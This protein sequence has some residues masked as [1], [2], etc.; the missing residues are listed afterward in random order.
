[1]RPVPANGLAQPLA[2]VV[3]IGK[4]RLPA[5]LGAQPCR[6]HGIPH[7]VAG[8]VGDMLV[9][10]GWL[11]HQLQDHF[12]NLF[13]VGVVIIGTNDVCLA[14][15]AFIDNAVDAAVVVV[16]VDPVADVFALAVQARLLV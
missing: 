3:I 1:V 6:I 7:V 13:I 14:N 8:A 11:I 4:Y 16:D 12:D 10:V 2:Q 9:P 15:G 5:E